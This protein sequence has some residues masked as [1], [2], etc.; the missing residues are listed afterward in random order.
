MG[1]YVYN[2]STVSLLPKN[3]RTDLNVLMEKLIRENRPVFG[4]RSEAPYYWIDIGQHAEY[5]KAN[6]EFERNREM[7]L[8]KGM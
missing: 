7:F 4:Y 3:E 5:E 6:H 2:R 8:G 1:I